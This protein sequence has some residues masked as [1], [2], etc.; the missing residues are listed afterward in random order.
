VQRDYVVNLRLLNAA[1]E[2]VSY[3]L[4]R[5]VRSGYPTHRWR[6]G[7]LVQDPWL[8]ALPAE[9]PASRY[10]LEL[11]LFDAETEAEI[12]RTLLGTVDLQAAFEQQK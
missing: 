1:N 11:V 5:P 12:T 2:E 9:L 10:S 7:Q 3:W 6:A 4:G 8:L